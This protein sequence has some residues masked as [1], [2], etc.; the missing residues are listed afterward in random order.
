MWQT[1]QCGLITDYEPVKH[2]NNSAIFKLLYL[3]ISLLVQD[4]LVIIIV[5]LNYALANRL[6]KYIKLLYF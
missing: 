5:K 4:K 6:I 2:R 1:E 3:K